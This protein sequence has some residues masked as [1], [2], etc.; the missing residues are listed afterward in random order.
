M[1]I[2]ILVIEIILIIVEIGMLSSFW[3]FCRKH[4]NEK[5]ET[6]FNYL[7]SRV[8]MLAV[9]LVLIFILRILAKVIG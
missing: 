5:I 3:R 9:I 2:A 7:N 6:H 8:T 1:K 4:R